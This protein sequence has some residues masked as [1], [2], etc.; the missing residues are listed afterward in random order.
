[1]LRFVL[2]VLSIMVILGFV[3]ALAVGQCRIMPWYNGYWYML[4]T[5]CHI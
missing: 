3:V 4:I 5:E 2:G 1:M